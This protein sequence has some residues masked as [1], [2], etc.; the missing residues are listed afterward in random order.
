MTAVA[1][2]SQQQPQTPLHN[3]TDHTKSVVPQQ[4][5]GPTNTE[6]TVV[7]GEETSTEPGWD[8]AE[9]ASLI[10]PFD[11]SAAARVITS[12][13]A[14][15]RASSALLREPKGIVVCC[16][17]YSEVNGG[18]S[19]DVFSRSFALAYAT[20]RRLGD[21]QRRLKDTARLPIH[22]F[23]F[24]ADCNA[25]NAQTS[26][27][28]NENARLAFH[29][30]AADVGVYDLTV[31][32][33]AISG[34]SSS[35]VVDDGRRA[36]SKG[37]TTT[38][39]LALLACRFDT[40]LTLRAGSIPLQWPAALFEAS[41]FITNGAFFWPA[42]DDAAKTEI[43]GNAFLWRKSSSDRDALLAVAAM[44]VGCDIPAGMIRKTDCSS[45][46]QRFVAARQIGVA[47]HHIANQTLLSKNVIQGLRVVDLS[48]ASPVSSTPPAQLQTMAR[49]ANEVAARVLPNEMRISA[50]RAAAAVRV[51]FLKKTGVAAIDSART[52]SQY[53]K[54]VTI[55]ARLRRCAVARQRGLVCRKIDDRSGNNQTYSETDGENRI[56][57][58]GGDA[59]DACD[60][61]PGSVPRT[62]I[63]TWRT[64]IFDEMKP[65][66]AN[67]M[68]AW[69]RRH[70]P[71]CWRYEAAHSGSFVIFSLAI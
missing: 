9:V 6:E 30:A 26:T 17:G 62:I 37:H 19:D 24:Q 63:Q 69:I 20:V 10:E 51:P 46:A 3:R 40:V 42:S 15:A 2:A 70:V 59:D 11:T 16:V 58:G 23:A 29:A 66:I 41:A 27:G 14:R 5:R 68:K 33:K 47:T 35:I 28:L 64:D 31:L 45:T 54:A 7:R 50:A 34:S 38:A 43:D 12:P 44:V 18:G 57:G 53:I 67:S 13:P 4:P 25:E 48:I 55:D 22:V 56:S 71:R 32:W 8:A 65:L 60:A 52:V 39:S 61:W 49:E 36:D 21:L 1:S